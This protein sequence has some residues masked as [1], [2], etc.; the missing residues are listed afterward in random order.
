MNIWYTNSP[1]GTLCLEEEGGALVG[2][3][4]RRIETLGAESIL[5]EATREECLQRLARDESRAA[6]QHQWIEYI[7]RWF[8]EYQPDNL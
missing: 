7:D 5:I 4:M 1:F 6:V 2:D 8:A 3:R